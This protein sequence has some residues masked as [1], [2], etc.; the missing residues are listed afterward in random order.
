MEIDVVFSD[1]EEMKRLSQRAIYNSAWWFSHSSGKPVRAKGDY[2]R[3]EWSARLR[4]YILPLGKGGNS[5]VV[6]EAIKDIG[7][8][9][10]ANRYVSHREAVEKTK[11]LVS[12][13]VVNYLLDYYD[14]Y[15]TFQ[16]RGVL[17]DFGTHSINVSVSSNNRNP[18]TRRVNHLA[19]P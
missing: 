15:P 12:G 9:V 7:K 13:C 2:R 6:S 14:S 8:N 19:A 16:D 3:V 17:I 10:K 18:F 5:L 4:E 1:L 11:N